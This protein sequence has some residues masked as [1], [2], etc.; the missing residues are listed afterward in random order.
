MSFNKRFKDLTGERFG[1]LT[2]LNFNG[3][4]KHSHN[5][6]LCKCDCG[7]LKL[8]STG[9]LTNGKTQSCGCWANELTVKR[10]TT[11]GDTH[12]RLYGIYRKMLW[13]CYNK[14]CKDYGR[15]GGRGVAICDEWKNSYEKF[16][17]W[18]L[19]NGYKKSLTI[20]R[21]DVDGDYEPSNCRW[22]TMKAQN[23]NKRNT[24]RITVNGV[25]KPL[26]MWA[27]EYKLPY[28]T[29]YNRYR[30]GLPVNEILK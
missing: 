28:T 14:N 19:D 5:I 16:K 27:K 1:R 30:K 2:V 6:W 21:I 4:D 10:N 26:S 23:V 3:K 24:I 11:H 7:N 20:D 22:V 25:R 18:A 8:V 13:R 9:D 12:T 15:Y 17:S 29:V